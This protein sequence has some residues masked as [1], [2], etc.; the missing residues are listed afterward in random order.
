MKRKDIT[1]GDTY[2]AL[3]PSQK[4][5]AYSLERYGARKGQPRPSTRIVTVLDVRP[6]FRNSYTGWGTDTRPRVTV[7]VNGEVFADV[8]DGTYQLG[9]KDN[10]YDGEAKR[11]VKVLEQT[12]RW[13]GEVDYKVGVVP[14]SMLRLT[15]AEFMKQARAAT[16]EKERVEKAVEARRA[17]LVRQQERA[18]DDARKLVDLLDDASLQVRIVDGTPAITGRSGFDA[19]WEF[20]AQAKS[21]ARVLEYLAS[22]GRDVEGRIAALQVELAS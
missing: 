4:V 20:V 15:L 21:D 1:V 8:P 16:R 14:L 2:V 3:S 18:R 12:R 19:L 5:D 13:N 10:D 7:E 11:G 22:E 17:D 6:E 9:P